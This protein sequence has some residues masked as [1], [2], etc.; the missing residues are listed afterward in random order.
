MPL[1][2]AA[3]VWTRCSSGAQPTCDD[4]SPAT[5]CDD[6]GMSERSPQWPT[7]VVLRELGEGRFELVGEVRRQP[8]LP[9]RAARARAVHDATLGQAKLGEA[10]AAI[11]R[12]EWRIAFD[13]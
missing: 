6:S 2:E 4:L 13:L 9:A 12:S 11:L 7:Y 3:S 10:Y 8:G 5:V 1:R